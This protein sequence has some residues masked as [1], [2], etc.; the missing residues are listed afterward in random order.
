VIAFT[1][2]FFLFLFFSRSYFFLS[3]FNFIL[4]FCYGSF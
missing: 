3:F 2:E 4:F 1:A